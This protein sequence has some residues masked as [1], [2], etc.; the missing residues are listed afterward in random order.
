MFRREG[1]YSNTWLLFHLYDET[2]KAQMFNNIH[3]NGEAN[4]IDFSLNSLLFSDLSG[5]RDVAATGTY[6]SSA[7]NSKLIF[8]LFEQIM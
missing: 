3:V 6:F 1:P 4:E 5:L 2:I 8:F 7:M